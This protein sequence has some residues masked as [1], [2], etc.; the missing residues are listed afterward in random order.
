MLERILGEDVRLE[1]NL[2]PAPLFVHADAGMLDQVLMNLAVNARDAMP[3]GGRLRIETAEQVIEAEQA[4]RH[5]EASPGRQV[6]ISVSDTGGGIPPEILPHIFEPFFTT[7]APGKGT[8]LGL[9]TVFGIVQQHRG[10]LEVES[11]PGQ[12]TTFHIFLP[13]NEAGTAAPDPEPTRARPIGGSE[14]ILLVEDDQAVRQVTQMLLVQHGYRVLEAADGVEALRLWREQ[15]GR[16]DLLITDLVMPEGLGGRELA[17]QLRA[18]R[19]GLKVI[20]TSGYSAEL[21]GRELTLGPGQAFL[22][23]PCPPQQL[24]ATV[25]TCLDS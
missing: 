8:G 24:L 7:K 22:P 21:A 14:T 16:I 17:A 18:Q 12:G 11:Q 19:P 2:H 4:R 5:P 3:N 15:E 6:R 10:W 13:A 9:A 1:L 23:K 25:R 20:F